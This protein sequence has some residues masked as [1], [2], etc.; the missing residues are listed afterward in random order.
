MLFHSIE[1]GLLLALT[2]LGLGIARRRGPS[3]SVLLIASYVFYGWW[4]VR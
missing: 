1:F 2:A 3:N 4:D